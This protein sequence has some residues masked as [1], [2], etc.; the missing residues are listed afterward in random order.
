MKYSI[1]KFAEI[2]GITPDTLRLYE[3]YNIITPKRDEQNNYR[4][5]DDLDV[6]DLLMSRWYRSMDISLQDSAR[7]ISNSSK[8]EILIELKDKKSI[9]EEEIYR[10]ERLLTRI[11]EIT[12]LMDNLDEKINLCEEKKIPGLYRLKQTNKNALLRNDFITEVVD[13]WMNFLP[14]TYYSFYIEKGLINKK[15]TLEYNWGLAINVEDIKGLDVEINDYVEYI[16][17]KTC[18]SSIIKSTHE[19][20]LKK[21]YF[22][23]MLD[24]IEENNYELV[25]ELYGNILFTESDENGKKSYLQVNIAVE[26]Q[27]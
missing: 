6:R 20:Y 7:L 21:D 15:D 3:K 19:Q 13:T 5:Y 16:P 27:N 23:F 18:I 26:E 22:Q 25:G 12:N 14:H 10:K 17:S 11:N 9:L 8:E 4:Y 24:Y 2:V 1:S